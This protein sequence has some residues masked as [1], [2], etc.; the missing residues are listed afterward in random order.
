[1]P[2]IR[3]NRKM[4]GIYQRGDR[5]V[6]NAVYR[7]QRIWATCATSQ[8]AVSILQKKRTEIDEGR[9]LDKKAVPTWTFGRLC[10]VY[11]NDCRKTELKSIEKVSSMVRKLR[12]HFGN[13]T[14]LKNVDKPSIQKFKDTY[15]PGNNHATTGGRVAVN[16]MLSQLK[17]MFQLAESHGQ[18]CGNPVAGIKK[19]KESQ[20]V[21]RFLDENEIF[22]LFSVCPEN[23]KKIVMLALLTAMR[24]SELYKLRWDQV[25]LKIG[26][27]EFP[28]QKN[29]RPGS[30]PIPPRAIELLQSIPR[31]ID[32]P[33][34]FPNKAGKPPVDF[35]KSWGK[36]LKEA[37]IENFRFHDLRHTAG[38]WMAMKGCSV[39][40]IME[41][42]RHSSPAMA[43]RYMHLS[44]KRKTETVLALENAIMGGIL[45]ANSRS[46]PALEKEA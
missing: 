13:D 35:K 26:I 20:G 21:V 43:I 34:V 17:A 30:I 23:L 45:G 29:G 3:K 16:R 8:M 2:K 18:H 7:Y 27:I 39:R 12:D 38:S 28:D 14:P 37:Q 32:S 22:R 10:D 1:M 46:L 31:R 9:F 40:D 25:K 42:M 6:V 19:F 15:T 4:A 11:L 36:V 44:P 5:W 33:Y 24:K 41:Q